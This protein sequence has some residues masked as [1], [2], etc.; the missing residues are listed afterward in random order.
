MNKTDLINAVAEKTEMTKKDSGIAVEAV[1]NTITE[2]L[3]EG[4]S[5]SV[6]GF[7]KFETRHRAARTARNP[8]TGD[9]IEVPATTVPA[10]KAGK[11]LKDAV[12]KGR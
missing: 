12:K 11:G 6:L 3:A 5:V 2:T 7:G 1:L 9:P 10:F 8:Q 4:D